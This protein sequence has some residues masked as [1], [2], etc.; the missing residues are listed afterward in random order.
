MIVLDGLIVEL[1]IVLLLNAIFTRTVQERANRN[2]KSET[3]QSVIIAK[4]AFRDQQ[5]R[6]KSVLQR[7]A[8]YMRTV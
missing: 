8:P 1:R 3:R 2:P 7:P 4:V 6:S 5:K